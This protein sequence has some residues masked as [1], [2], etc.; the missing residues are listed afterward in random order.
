MKPSR[1][2]AQLRRVSAELSPQA[3]WEPAVRDQE[4]KTH[5]GASLPPGPYAVGDMAIPGHERRVLTAEYAHLLLHGRQ[6]Q[7]FRLESNL[8]DTK[9][10]SS[11]RT[12]PGIR[13][14]PDVSKSA[15]A[16]SSRAA[17]RRK[18][19]KRVT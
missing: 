16:G 17:S 4:G 8:L 18:S 1:H 15:A 3:A 10:L 14:I 13:L 12:A 2:S 19:W 6:L 9:Y 11:A 5:V 7:V